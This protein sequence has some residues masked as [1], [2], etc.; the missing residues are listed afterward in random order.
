MPETSIIISGVSTIP[1]LEDNLRIF[2][3]STPGVMTESEQELIA[4][5]RG[6]F[7]NR[8]QVN[9]TGCR[10]CLPCPQGL[11]IP[12]LFD[13]Y[14]DDLLIAGLD[15]NRSVYQSKAAN[16]QGGD[17]CSSCGHCVDRCP[18][19]LAVPELMKELHKYFS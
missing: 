17:R 13:F 19:K 16:K 18:Q 8:K 3:S 6:V 12:A 7:E 2:A 4:R 14:N 11:D 5:I 15:W 1:Q 9:C 10:Y